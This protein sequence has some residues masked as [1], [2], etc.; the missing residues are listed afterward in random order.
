[1]I[2]PW[3]SSSVKSDDEEENDEKNEEQGCVNDGETDEPSKNLDKDSAVISSPLLLSTVDSKEKN[4]SPTKSY[5]AVK[6]ATETAVALNSDLNSSVTGEFPRT[7]I[8]YYCF[9]I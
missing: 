4:Y 3:N 6:D 2:F 8:L 7:L 1:M 9:S 5:G